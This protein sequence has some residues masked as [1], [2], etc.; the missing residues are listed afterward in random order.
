MQVEIV[1]PQP[2]PHYKVGAF[3]YS[4]DDK[5]VIVTKDTCGGILS[6]AFYTYGNKEKAVTAAWKMANLQSRA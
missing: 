5:A 4:V 1:N 2:N 3:H 6:V